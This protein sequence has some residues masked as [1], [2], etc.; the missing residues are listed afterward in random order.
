MPDKETNDRAESALDARSLDTLEHLSEEVHER[1]ID[2]SI[3][4]IRVDYDALEVEEGVKF[5]IYR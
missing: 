3:A 1:R 5:L 4:H 2:Q